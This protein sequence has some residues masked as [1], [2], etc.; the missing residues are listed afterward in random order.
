[1]LMCMEGFP[2][3]FDTAHARHT[4]SNQKCARV[5]YSCLQPGS[6]PRAAWSA[7]SGRMLGHEVKPYVV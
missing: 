7:S 4:N 3:D 6:R 1:M 2:D 5:K